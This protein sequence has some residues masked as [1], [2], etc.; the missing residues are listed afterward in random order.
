MAA[1][2]AIESISRLD[3]RAL[4]VEA[5]HEVGEEIVGEIAQVEAGH[6]AGRVEHPVHGREGA[7]ALGHALERVARLALAACA[8]PSAASATR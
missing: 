3:R 2:T 5:R 4:G 8:G 6:V 1:D 7:D